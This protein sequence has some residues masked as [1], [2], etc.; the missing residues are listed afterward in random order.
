MY[1]FNLKTCEILVP[2][3]FCLFKP[4][5][6]AVEAWWEVSNF[7]S[8]FL[9]ISVVRH[10]AYFVVF[11]SCCSFIAFCYLCVERKVLMF[12]IFTFE[13]PEGCFHFFILLLLLSFSLL[14]CE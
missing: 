4:N 2:V 1:F 13:A 9:S 3:L 10:G 14:L 5:L 6:K 11:F 12:A 8:F 7:I